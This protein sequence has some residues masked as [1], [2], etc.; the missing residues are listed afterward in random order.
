MKKVFNLKYAKDMAKGHDIKVVLKKNY[1]GISLF[2]K[3]PIKKGSVVAYY[4]LF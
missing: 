4:K 3:K 2:S 1:K